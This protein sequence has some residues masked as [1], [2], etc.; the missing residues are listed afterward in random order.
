M[1]SRIIPKELTDWSEL[2]KLD[3]FFS[4]I[5][6][7]DE[8]NFGIHL[9]NGKLWSSGYVGVGRL[10]N[11]NGRPI[12][13]AG[14]EHVA[15]MR[16]QYN[17]DPWVM[18]E[19]VMTDTEYDDYIKELEKGKKYLFKIFYDQPV[20]KL[21]Q[22]VHCDSDILYALS[23]INQA[24]SLCKKGIKNKMVKHEE[25]LVCKVKGRIDVRKNIRINTCNGRNDRFY[26]K[27]IDF[28][29]DT[30]ENR[31]LK[32]TLIKCKRILEEKFTINSEIMSRLFFCMGSLK[33]VKT[34]T[35]RTRDFNNAN[36][37]G[38]YTYY[39]PLMKQ[40][41]AILSQKYNKYVADDG[42]SVSRSVYVIPYMINMEAV[43]EFYARRIFKESL[44]K[45]NY[46]LE[47]Y[48]KRLY[49]Q[50]GASAVA[51]GKTDIHLMQ[52]CIP[53]IIVC[54]KNTNAP[55]LVMDAKYKD[56]SR[57]NREDSHQL[58]SYTLLTGA[59]KCGFVMPGVNT[60]IKDMGGKDYLLI[61]TPLIQQLKYY[62]LLLGE[63]M[64]PTE[65]G[66][67]F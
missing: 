26:C 39:K 38:L 53:D 8:R 16:S 62:E 41:K 45:N 24:Y 48:S 35:I 55:V 2:N 10:Y 4:E 1:T 21:D 31:I 60:A 3:P 15:I 13:T 57:S 46:Y 23:F 51:G 27:Y 66:K 64:N 22:D 52:Y 40:A 5:D 58:L 20:I 59:A 9:Y 54:D 18:L 28:T 17:I 29:I 37:S 33:A 44:D 49:L 30:I 36:T 47:K 19:K 50:R 25:N 34:V 11:K 14:R 32:A 67:L 6:Y 61:E 63:T 12:C 7:A 43:F 65:F 56:D 42:N